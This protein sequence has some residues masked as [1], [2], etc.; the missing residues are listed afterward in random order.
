MI[1]K[2]TNKSTAILLLQCCL[3]LQPWIKLATKSKTEKIEMTGAHE[4]LET[5]SSLGVNQ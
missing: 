4:N 1:E 5:R 2:T 3:L